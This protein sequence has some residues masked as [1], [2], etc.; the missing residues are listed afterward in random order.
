MK[1]FI[2]ALLV[3]AVLIAIAIV[4]VALLHLAYG[5][6]GIRAVTAVISTGLLWFVYVKL[7]EAENQTQWD[8]DHPPVTPKHD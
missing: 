3:T 6:V 4:A 8:K 2:L 7:K 1:T 5:L